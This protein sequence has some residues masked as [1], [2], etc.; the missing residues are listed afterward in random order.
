MTKNELWSVKQR[1]FAAL[2]ETELVPLTQEFKPSKLPT[3]TVEAYK[4]E[5]WD[6]EWPPKRP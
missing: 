1:Q 4:L 5:P 3:A 6:N 2:G